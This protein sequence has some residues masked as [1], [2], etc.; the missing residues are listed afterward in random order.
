MFYEE[1]QKIEGDQ[2]EMSETISEKK[3]WILVKYAHAIVHPIGVAGILFGFIVLAGYLG[4]IE[5]LYR[6]FP[7]GPA[8]NPLTA[9]C[10]IFI[11]VGLLNHHKTNQDKW[12]QRVSAFI[13]ILITS[14][15]LIDVMTHF[16]I[17]ASLTP[18]QD[19]VMHDLQL[20]KSNS[21]GINSTF[22]FL[23]IAISLLLYN[24]KRIICSQLV[25][26]IA[27][28]LPTVSFTGYLYQVEHFYGEMSILTT[29]AGFILVSATLAMTA[30]T[31]GVKAVLSPYTG[32]KIAR[33][34]TI[35]GYA[36]PTIFGYVFMKTLISD[37]GTFFALYVVFLSWFIILMISISAIFYENVDHDRRE[38]ERLLAEAAL[39]DPLTKVSNRRKLF[40][41]G[42]K[43][44]NRMKRSKQQL[45]FLLLDIDY[46][47]KV[48][49][50]AGH[51][52]GDRVLV[53]IAETLQHS[54]R[55]IDLVSRIGGEEF[56]II[57][58]DT[59]QEGAE[60]VAEKIRMNIEQTSIEGWT[61]T[62]GPV[63]VSIGCT[64]NN[65]DCTLEETI[66]F[67]DE[68]L[69]RAKE[70]GRNRVVFAEGSNCDS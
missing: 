9:M 25:A 38:G 29:I 13:I 34:Q 46:F 50:T 24:F 58:V 15:R 4:S 5:V 64:A 62:H 59:T 1:V 48:N 32:G 16:Q 39:V 69:Y 8:T 19:Q 51:D 20:G 45:W 61:D 10:I 67:A 43:E 60:R 57:L 63:T 42:K 28:A 37:G 31:G 2:A 22:M 68:A 18:F 7:H 55:S 17:S 70:S 49:D 40:E 65:G 56:S 6:P 12:L 33:L 53:K 23:H 27:L 44:I 35:I 52:V 47:K 54:V 11:G 3:E 26:F 66:K 14:A 41:F 30:H 36:F 21:M